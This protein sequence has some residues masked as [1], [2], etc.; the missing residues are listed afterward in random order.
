MR[1]RDEL[2]GR[3]LI[4]L[5]DPDQVVIKRYGLE[6]ES[7]GRDL[8]RPATFI[9]DEEGVIRWRHLPSDWRNRMGPTAY[10]AALDWVLGD[11]TGPPPDGTLAP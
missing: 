3:G 1:Y 6:D 7:L 4:Y 11:M 10:L 8:A 5:S 2:V 9:L